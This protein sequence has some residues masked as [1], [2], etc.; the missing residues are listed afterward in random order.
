MD[1]RSPIEE[2]LGVD[3]DSPP[4]RGLLAKLKGLILNDRSARAEEFED[5]IIDTPPMPAPGAAPESNDELAA[6]LTPLAGA[7][8]LQEWLEAERTAPLF[9]QYQQA[10]TRGMARASAGVLL[11]IIA[12]VVCAW[13]LRIPYW[14]ALKVALQSQEPGVQLLAGGHVAQLAAVTATLLFPLLALLALLRSCAWLAGITRPARAAAAMVALT[15]LTIATGVMLGGQ[16][17]LG[18]AI[19]LTGVLAGE[20]VERWW[21]GGR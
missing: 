21:R 20:M 17:L 5:V 15:A 12:F 2:E 6:K 13:L 8:H 4:K 9:D 18:C 19:V 16:A 3:L 11:G 10:A 7:N 1:K 14:D